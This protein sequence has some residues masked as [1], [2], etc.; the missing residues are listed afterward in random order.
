MK[1]LFI[2]LTVI[3]IATMTKVKAQTF[4]LK[5]LASYETTLDD[6]MEIIDKKLVKEKLKE[7]ED[8]FNKNSN[9][10]NTVRLGLIYHD[11]ALN[12]TFFDKTKEYAGYAQ[13]SYDVL[14]K[15]SGNK[16]TTPELM[17]FIESYRASS[18]SLIAGETKKLSLLGKAFEIFA[19]TIEKYASVSPRPEF[20]RGSVSE[21]LPFFMWKKRKFARVDFESIIKK[22][23]QNTSYADFR[24][25]SFSYWAWARANSGKKHR[26][27]AIEYLNKAIEI[28]PNYKA[29]RKRAEEL[30]AKYSRQ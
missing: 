11:I 19:N 30:K 16:N 22:Q 24:I 1:H 25:M 18:L 8:V 15:L 14:T 20:M 28:D 10:L 3:T 9:E 13:K 4:D 26:K 17:V 12:L 7:V 6:V 5:R 29:G 2:L 21:N 27:Q 23:K